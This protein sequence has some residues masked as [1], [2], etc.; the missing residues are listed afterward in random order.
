MESLDLKRK[1]IRQIFGEAIGKEP[2]FKV[3]TSASRRPKV[4]GPLVIVRTPETKEEY[5][6][7][8]PVLYGCKAVVIVSLIVSGP[9]EP[10]DLMDELASK[11]HFL[12]R[13]SLPGKFEKF[14]R[15]QTQTESQEG[16]S[17]LSGKID[18][19]YEVTYT[20]K[21]K[22]PP[23]GLKNFKGVTLDMGENS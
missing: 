4:S 12:L 7:G 23:E 15:L 2:A 17:E 10:E 5:L 1:E 16:G 13:E 8:R 11:I 18:L 21:D 19:Y 6:G 14:R 3:I 20:I 9:E 22:S